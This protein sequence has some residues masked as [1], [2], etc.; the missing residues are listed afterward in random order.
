MIIGQTQ[1]LTSVAL[2]WRDSPAWL[3]ALAPLDIRVAISTAIIMGLDGIRF[4]KVE[5]PPLSIWHTCLIA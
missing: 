1:L 2:T 5:V 3:E 4:F